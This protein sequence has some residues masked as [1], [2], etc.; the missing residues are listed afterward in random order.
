MLVDKVQKNRS[1]KI[2]ELSWGRLIV[3]GY[4]DPFKDVKLFPGGA[5]EWDWTETG[6]RHVPGIQPADITE[7]IKKG[8][9]T[10]ILST[11]MQQRVLVNPDTHK[12]L[13]DRGIRFTVLPTN[14]AVEI[15]NE[16][17]VSE[18]VGALIH[19]TC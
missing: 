18:A 10:V 15:Y 9:R 11:G 13:S 6:T 2:I 14:E 19:S 7:L 17:A 12:W 5:R 8:A 4:P 16:L 1:P 3:E